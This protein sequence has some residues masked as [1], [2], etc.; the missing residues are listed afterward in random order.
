M[1]KYVKRLVKCGYSEEHAYA[2]CCDFIRNL[3]IVDLENFVSSVEK[4][5]NVYRV[6]S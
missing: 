6:Q 5:A 1:Q 3:S 2:V 4:R